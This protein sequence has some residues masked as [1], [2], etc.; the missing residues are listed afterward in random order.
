MHIYNVTI[1]IDDS[2]H[3]EWK[4]WMTEIHIPEVLSTGLFIESRFGRVLIEEESGTTYSIQYLFNEKS[5]YQLYEELYAKN[6]RNKTEDRFAG[7]FVAFRTMLDIINIQK[8]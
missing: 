7:K 2:V 5:N 6:I 3:E 8:K 1:N 4:V